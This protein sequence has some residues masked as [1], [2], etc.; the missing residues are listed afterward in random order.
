MRNLKEYVNEGLAD[1]SDSDEFDKKISKQTTKA[2]IKK[3]IIDWLKDNVKTIK[4]TNLKFDFNTTPITV[5][6][7]GDIKFK[8]NITSLTN[9]IFQ[10]GVVGGDFSCA[11][12]KSLKTLEGAPKYVGKDFM[13]VNC[14]SLETLEGAPKETGRHFNCQG[15]DSLKNL[16]GSSEKVGLDFYCQGCKSLKSLEGAPKE[17]ARDFYC[18][19]CGGQFAK[20]DVKKVSDVKYKIICKQW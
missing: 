9:D 14:I 11:F 18:F 8:D 13:C 12:C 15:C 10:W 5:N 2:A 1:W 6:Y 17:V 20:E 19:N 3:E 16:E 4:K 7:D